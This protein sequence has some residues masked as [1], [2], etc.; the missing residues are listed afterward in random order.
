MHLEADDQCDVVVDLVG[1][2]R[3]GGRLWFGWNDPGINVNETELR[4]LVDNETRVA[5]HDSWR[6]CFE[7]AA[8]GHRRWAS[9]EISVAW[10]TVEERFL[11]PDDLNAIA[12]YL[13]YPP[14]YS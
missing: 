8:A 5:T 11:F 3:V 12:V 13:Y 1:K 14:A 10:E 7:R 2:V 9:G 4:E 6:D